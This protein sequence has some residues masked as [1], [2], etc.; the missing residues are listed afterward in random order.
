MFLDEPDASM[1]TYNF[2]GIT[3]R[4]FPEEP[5]WLPEITWTVSPLLT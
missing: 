3:C 5:R 1:I 2:Q 4:I